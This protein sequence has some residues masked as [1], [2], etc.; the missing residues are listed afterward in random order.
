[1]NS[2]SSPLDSDYG[3]TENSGDL[4]MPA[5]IDAVLIP[6]DIW[7]AAHLFVNTGINLEEVLKRLGLNVEQWNTVNDS[8]RSLQS[9]GYWWWKVEG[10]SNAATDP[11]FLSHVLKDRELPPHSDQFDLGMELA[12]I[13]ATVRAHPYIGAFESIRWPATFLGEH[14][15]TN[16]VIYSRNDQEVFFLGKPLWARNQAPL[17]GIDAQSFRL[18]SD[19]WMR[20]KNRV[21]AQGQ[22]GYD[23]VQYYFYAL[24]GADPDS[25]EPLNLRYAKDKNSAYYITRKRIRTKSV[26]NFAI[27]PYCVHTIFGIDDE[28]THDSMYARDSEHVYVSGVKLADADPKTFKQVV[29]GDLVNGEYFTDGKNVWYG[30]KLLKNADAESFTVTDVSQYSAP[31]RF[32]TYSRGIPRLISRVYSAQGWSRYF[33]ARPELSEY[34]WYRE[35]QYLKS[36]A[37]VKRTPLGGDYSTDGERIYI[38]DIW[39]EGFSPKKFR[40]IEGSFCVHDEK[41]YSYAASHLDFL[42]GGLL[43]DGDP[44][45]FEALT[46]GWYADRN[47]AYFDVGRGYSIA[48]KIHRSSFRVIDKNHAE[49]RD[50]R[51]PRVK[52][53]RAA[54]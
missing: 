34:W 45:T 13:R 52:R 8:F 18:L 20:D 3:R 12:K 38:S 2:A 5:R 17:E 43:E 30:A 4:V 11:K 42:D 53:R 50:G 47:N 29:S 54:K 44:S 23:R 37:S 27:V 48:I 41:L 25:F 36:K 6:Y 40:H 19:R 51:I 33:K 35:D 14:Y 22:L 28:I 31:D 21:Y 15:Q 24:E 32:R 1:M 46:F 7:V 9:A 26:A 10:W 49:D 16:G 39:I